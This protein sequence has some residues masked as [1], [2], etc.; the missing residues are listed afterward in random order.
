MAQGS[1]KL[2]TNK[3]TGGQEKKMTATRKA[4]KVGK[5][6]A[7]PKGRK[8]DEARPDIAVSKAL[9]KKA[10]VQTSAKAIAS[11]VTVEMT[12]LRESGKIELK[13]QLKTRNKKENRALKLTDRLKSQLRKLGRDV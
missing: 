3:K 1:A 9:A 8:A 7:K 2:G 6:F 12:D 10:E 11:G 5:K 13:T 4:K